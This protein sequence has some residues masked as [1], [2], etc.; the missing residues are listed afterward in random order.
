MSSVDFCKGGCEDRIWACEAK[1]SPLLEATAREQMVK[2]QQAGEGFT[3]ALVICK[4]CRSDIALQV[5]VV[6]S[7]VYNWST[8]SFSNPN[9]VYS[10]PPK[11]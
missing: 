8:N 6:P 9:P 5:L 4:V 7:C 3:G 11:S 10:H 1:E 2:T